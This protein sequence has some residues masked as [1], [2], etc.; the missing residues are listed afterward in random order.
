MLELAKVVF[1]TR[2][3]DF[4]TLGALDLQGLNLKCDLIDF[5][6]ADVYLLVGPL[7]FEV[8]VQKEL[9]DLIAI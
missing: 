8:L 1:I 3:H 7:P 4:L 2:L 6:L 5:L 9:L